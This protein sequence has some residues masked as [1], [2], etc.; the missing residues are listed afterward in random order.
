VGVIQIYF[1]LPLF[2]KD[3]SHAIVHSFFIIMQ[4]Q[5][6]TEINNEIERLN[7]L[8]TEAKQK[9]KTDLANGFKAQGEQLVEKQKVL[10][11]LPKVKSSLAI[12]PFR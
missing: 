5:R 8:Y 6:L 7:R 1:I 11:S 4:C 12:F 2:C 9:G 10:S 3:Q